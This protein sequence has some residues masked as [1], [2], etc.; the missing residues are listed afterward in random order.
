[1]ELQ[2]KEVKED[3]ANMNAAESMM[4]IVESK[5]EEN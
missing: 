3:Q 4:D 2:A 1:M 5:I